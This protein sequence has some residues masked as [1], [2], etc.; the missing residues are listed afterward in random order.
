MMTGKHS[1]KKA[2]LV[3]ATTGTLMAPAAFAVAEGGFG[4]HRMMKSHHSGKHLKKMAHKLDLS[5]AQVEQ[6]K[7]IREQ[8]K[9]DMVSLRDTMKTFK[10]QVKTEQTGSDFDE[11]AFATT[12]AQYQ[13][14]FEKMALL[15]AK[16]AHAIV[17]VL[18]PEQQEKWQTMKEKRKNRGGR[19]ER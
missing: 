12:Y 19:G 15:R 3:L 6:I 18:T 17:N 14:S 16:M 2:L 11:A 13:D 4:E 5:D 10:E 1:I 9:E 7:Q 8:N